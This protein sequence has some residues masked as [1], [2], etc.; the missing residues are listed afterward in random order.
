L[1]DTDAAAG[2]LNQLL[3]AIPAAHRALARTLLTDPR[4]GGRG[5]RAWLARLEI[6]DRP[7]PGQ[8]PDELV[9]VYLRDD[10]AEPLH[11]CERCGLA[12]PVRA[13]RRCGHEAAV[14]RE[15]FPTCPHCGGRTGRHAYWSRRCVPATN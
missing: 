5:L 1:N 7:V 6:D 15:Y 2:L 3:A 9:E 13:A 12:V 8:L 11:D 4:C 10:E 14:E